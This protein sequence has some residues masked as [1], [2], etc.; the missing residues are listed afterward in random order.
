MNKKCDLKYILLISIILL[1]SSCSGVKKIA[2]FQELNSKTDALKFLQND[3][4][5]YDA[6]IKPKDLL[7][8]TV[9]STEPEASQ[10]YNLVTPQ[11]A[12][13]SDKGSV[14]SQPMLQNYLVDNNGIINFP[15]LG[16]IQVSEL[17]RKELELKLQK[18]LSSAFTKEMPIITIRINNYSVSILGEVVKPGKFE[19]NNDRITI[20]EGLALAG[21][22]TI[23]GRRD[24]VKVL[25][26]DAN[27]TK[28][29]YT[30]N[31]SDKNIIFSPAYF[32]EQNDIVYVE[33]NKSKSKSANYGSAESFR[34]TTYS[35]FITL[36]S[37]VVTL[38]TAFK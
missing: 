15:V 6:R 16:K 24:N 21:D 3:V 31:L 17:T 14:Y 29:Y 22:M 26:E 9:V 5:L 33:P 8:I 11:T 34:I 18:M 37:L 32:L 25:R 20:L 4:G 38:Y 28:K 7:A 10:I 23:Y 13:T 1:V 19:T 12:G 30:I 36:T 27:G 2:Y 35:L